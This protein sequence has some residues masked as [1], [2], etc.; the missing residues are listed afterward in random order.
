MRKHREEGKR[1]VPPDG[2]SFVLND[3]FMK[4]RL[5]TLE[6]SSVVTQYEMV[7]AINAKDVQF[8]QDLGCLEETDLNFELT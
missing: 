7:R 2:P 3:V 4:N 5:S 6:V 1:Q 8:F